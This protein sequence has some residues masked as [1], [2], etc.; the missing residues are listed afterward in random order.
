M[1]V[2]YFTK[3]HTFW[4]TVKGDIGEIAIIARM[5]LAFSS[6]L[7]AIRLEFARHFSSV[8]VLRWA[9]GPSVKSSGLLARDV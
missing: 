5:R 9:K 7:L 3:S 4:N 2:P 8:K 6:V 1:R